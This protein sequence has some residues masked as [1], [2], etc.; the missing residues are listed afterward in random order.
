MGGQMTKVGIE[1]LAQVLV[2]KHGQTK[3][4]AENFIRS[5]FEVVD[6]ALKRERQ[7]KIKGW[8]TFKLTAV[9]ER[10]SINVNTGERIVIGGRDKIAFTPDTVLRDI[11]N[12]PFA[13]F[14]TVVLN[15]GVDFTDIDRQIL[16][17]EASKE[18]APNEC[19]PKLQ[20]T[21]GT[22]QK[23]IIPSRQTE[24]SSMLVVTSEAQAQP[25]SKEE[26]KDNGRADIELTAD[27]VAGAVNG[28]VLLSDNVDESIDTDKSEKVKTPHQ[29]S[30]VL[31]LSSILLITLVLV[32]LLGGVGMLAFYYGQRNAKVS[33]QSVSTPA[34][35]PTHR[36]VPKKQNLA[37]PVTDSIVLSK[38]KADSARILREQQA[39]V[40]AEEAQRLAAKQAKETKQKVI[41]KE[42]EKVVAKATLKVQPVES[43]QYDND[44]RIRTG[45]YRIVGVEKVITLKAGQTLSSIGKSYL[46]AGMDCYMEA[47][48]SKNVKVGDKVKIPRLQLKRHK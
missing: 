3:E 31:S 4:Q 48:N 32:G 39:I 46:G 19:D 12:K 7:L 42:N 30:F 37:V 1:E 5:M 11:I 2:E 14:E 16:T 20:K 17:T 6:E 18:E 35:Q 44:P 29:R 43:N 26:Y 24:E 28:A 15:E 9:K 36:V 38:A 25:S 23:S 10:E 13:H 8:G 47:L 22:T 34:V 27:K 40:R 33:L 21:L 41:E 45:A